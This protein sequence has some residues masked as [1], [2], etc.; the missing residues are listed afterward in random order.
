L[1]TEESRVA[2]L[3]ECC[4]ASVLRRHSSSDVL[5]D[6]AVEMISKLVIEE[7]RGATTPEKR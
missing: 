1:I 5:V 7:R 3:A 6:L 2:E 4:G